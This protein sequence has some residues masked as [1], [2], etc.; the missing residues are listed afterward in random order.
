MV[1]F[2][3]TREE[4]A[5][6]NVAS[7]DAARMRL[8]GVHFNS[9]VAVAT[10]GHVLAIRKKSGGD[11]APSNVTLALPTNPK[12]KGNPIYSQVAERFVDTNGNVAEPVT[13]GEFPDY[14]QVI[15]MPAEDDLIV[16]FDAT[17]LMRLASALNPDARAKDSRSI[18]LRI[19]RSDPSAVVTVIGGDAE[20]FGVLMPYRKAMGD[21]A[22][23][24]K[25]V[26]GK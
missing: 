7:T 10:N 13:Q 12:G 6:M 14:S 3:I 2:T 1:S 8:R 23:R 16:S 26:M 20:S 19:N 9:R 15:P 11:D 25:E 18:T 17:E 5:L 24:A 22:V 4:H 21:P